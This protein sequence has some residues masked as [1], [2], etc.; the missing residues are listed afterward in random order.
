MVC[1]SFFY[2]GQ[3][4]KIYHKLLTFGF[5]LSPTYFG[6]EGRKTITVTY[7]GKTTTFE[8][9]VKEESAKVLSYIS[10]KSEPTKTSYYVEDYLDTTGPELTAHYSDGSTKT[11]TSGFTCSPM[12]FGSEGTKQVT[13][14]YEGKTTSFN[15]SVFGV[16]S[17]SIN[18]YPRKTTYFANDLYLDTTG[19]SLIVNYSDGSYKAVSTGFTCTP[20]ELPRKSGYYTITVSYGGKT[21]S[22]SIYK[23]SIYSVIDDE[24]TMVG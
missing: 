23:C 20:T 3:L 14:T 19:L 4:T 7:D 10:I 13:V 6:S 11:I 18:S 5:S 1:H 16:T 12:Y 21:T 15:V 9:T 24:G 17:I 2:I 8:V 22:F